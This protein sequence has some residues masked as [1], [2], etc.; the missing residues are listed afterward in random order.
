MKK[1]LFLLLALATLSCS[2]KKQSKSKEDSHN[3]EQSVTYTCSMHPQITQDAPGSCPICGMAL[4]E[5]DQ[6]TSGTDPSTLSFTQEA[7]S[8]MKVETLTVG[9]SVSQSTSK[10]LSGSIQLDATKRFDET[11]KYGGRIERLFVHSEGEV[12]RKGQKIAEIFSPEIYKAQKE[13]LIAAGSKNSQPQYYKA[14]REKLRIM[15]FSDQWIDA[16][17]SRGEA[18]AY[19]DLVAESG[20]TLIDLAV[21]EGDAVKR[22]QLL[23][24]SADLSTV[25]AQLD[26]YE[27]DLESVSLGQRVLLK[28]P[29]LSTFSSEGTVSFI[30]KVINEKTRTYSIRVEVP[31]ESNTLK[32]GMFV[33]AT[34][35]PRNSSGLQLPASAILWTGKRS[36]VYVQ[37]ASSSFE[38]REVEVSQ[39]NSDYYTVLS[40]LSEGES[41][42]VS[43]AF[44][45][46]A[47]AQLR[48]LESMM[49]FQSEASESIAPFTA[50]EDSMMRVLVQPYLTLK[51]EL[52]RSDT[53]AASASAKEMLVL[54]SDK[55]YAFSRSNLKPLLESIQ[56][57][58][59]IEEQREL[60]RSISNEMIQ[61][62]STTQS[63]SSKLYVQF[64]PMA[65]N[66]KGA[67]WLSTQEEIRN[68]FYGDTMLTC[69][70]VVD[71]LE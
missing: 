8:L 49:S 32:P 35:E 10:E 71:I 52:V 57:T 38:L 7:L 5:K 22:G 70:S 21:T 64:C 67:S 69:G 33:R 42:V 58:D 4:I 27:N 59:D 65:N 6:N 50:Q 66:N 17:E 31:N 30:D 47:S 37:T 24:S 18:Q 55:K 19:F 16:L 60:F 51:D 46:D 36:L 9:E 63:V 54:L 34:L 13:L 1:Q 20:G 43:G 15:K 28:S 29:N 39:E 44:Q 40:G 62:A 2:D 3:H 25:W 11:T 53:Q 12:I 41:V 45:M 68:P 26:G 61:W 56:N 14:V 48:G 23:Y